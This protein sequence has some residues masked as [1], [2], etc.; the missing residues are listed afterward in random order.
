MLVV[1]EAV[2]SIDPARCCIVNSC[3]GADDRYFARERFEHR[4]AEAFALGGDDDR[5]GSVDP[6]RNLLRVY[7]AEREKLGAAAGAN[8][9]CAVETLAGARRVG[10]EE[11]V[12]PVQN[13]S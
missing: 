6:K 4:E 10:W 3:W 9:L 11:Q 2:C 8:R 7:R 13:S 1:G 12:A 5:I